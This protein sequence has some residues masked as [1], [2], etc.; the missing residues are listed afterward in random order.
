MLLKNVPGM[1]PVLENSDLALSKLWTKNIEKIV[2][3]QLTALIVKTLNENPESKIE[4]EIQYAIKQINNAQLNELIPEVRISA[5]TTPSR[6]F[7][8][9][10][11]FMCGL[12]KLSMER[13]R[14]VVFALESNMSIS[15]VRNMTRGHAQQI[16]PQ[17][18]SSMAKE[19][20]RTNVISIKSG[21]A[22]WEKCENKHVQLGDLE[23]HVYEAFGMTYN[24]LTKRYTNMIF[25]DFG[26][27]AKV[28]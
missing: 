16:Q 28:V 24:Q 2:P 5:Y 17:L 21:Y 6:Q 22:F 10:S 3:E 14:A 7:I 23:Q 13:R 15:K 4:L 8:S 12:N 9:L 27:L 26:L 11:K 18:N 20:L 19:I 1:L 25:D